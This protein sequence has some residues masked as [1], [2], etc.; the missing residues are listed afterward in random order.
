MK[1]GFSFILLAIFM[2]LAGC[3]V[4][5]KIVQVQRDS[6]TVFV[7]DSIHVRDTIVQVHFP[8]ESASS[9]LPDSDTSTLRT[10]VA[11]SVAYVR[12]GQLHHELRNRSD[13]VLPVRVQ[14]LD[15]ARSIRES[16]IG[17]RHTT[18][19]IEVERELTRW[20]KFLLDLGLV[21]FIAGSLAICYMII[22]LFQ[23]FL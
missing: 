20:Q 18:E 13:A 12:S 23:R 10:S 1:A 9:V 16:H 4:P 6:A 19:I 7:R 22:R 8:P 17:L 5:G 21:T 3:T 14:I 2:S 15:R 11:V